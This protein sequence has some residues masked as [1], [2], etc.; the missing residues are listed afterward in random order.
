M[1][2]SLERVVSAWAGQLW[3][4][5]LDGAGAHPTGAA[6]IDVDSTWILD[7]WQRELL[8][9]L[10]WQA[11]GGSVR[12]VESSCGG[13]RTHFLHLLHSRARRWGLAT[14]LIPADRQAQVW[15]CPLELYRD[16]LL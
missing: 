7:E 11:R 6:A 3:A 2:E 1:E 13:G 9:R 14:C 8:E 12:F 16:F 15:A 5:L 10:L 4:G